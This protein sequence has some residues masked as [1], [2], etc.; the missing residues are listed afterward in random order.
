MFQFLVCSN[1]FCRVFDLSLELD[2]ICIL[3]SMEVYFHLGVF[4]VKEF[5]WEIILLFVVAQ[6]NCKVFECFS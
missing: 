2:Q 3:L 6:F 1:Q 4:G 5:G